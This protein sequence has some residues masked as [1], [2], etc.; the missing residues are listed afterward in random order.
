MTARVGVVIPAHNEGPNIPSC[1]ASVSTQSNEIRALVSD[2]GST[3]GTDEVLERLRPELRFQ[4]RRA[5][6]LGPSTHLIDC[7]RWLLSSGTEPYVAL[8]AADDT[9]APGFAEAAV[10]VLDADEGLGMVFPACTWIGDGTARTL[11]PLDFGARSSLAR[12]LHA[13]TAPYRRELANQ[14]Y[15]L[16]RR[17]A[18]RQLLDNWERGGDVFASDYAAVVRTLA[19]FRSRPA[20]NALLLRSESDPSDGLFYSR[21]GIEPRPEP[22]TTVEV[23]KHYAKNVSLTDKAVSG[24]LSRTYGQPAWLAAVVVRPLRFPLMLLTVVSRVAHRVHLR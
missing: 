22:R 5:E 6:G 13:V 19:K 16:F 2:N 21:I 24:A 4:S 10:A 17:E 14:V 11:A 15:G 8:L 12:Q 1:L 9:W 20:P 18:F 7:G 23:A 3:D